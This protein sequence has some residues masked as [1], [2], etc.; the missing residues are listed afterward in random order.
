MFPCNECAKL[1]I[2]AGITEVVYHEVRGAAAGGRRAGA[3]APV[4]CHDR[5]WAPCT[6]RSVLGMLLRRQEPEEPSA[7][8]RCCWPLLQ[9]KAQEQVMPVRSICMSDDAPPLQHQHLHLHH[10]HQHHQHG[11]SG[12]S[13][14]AGAQEVCYLA[15]KRLLSLA[16]VRLRQHQLSHSV[17]LCG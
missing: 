4:S 2:Q 16:G 8:A 7:A 5:A 6:W 11:S 13:S 15:S 14:A 12:G 10:G 1:L 3:P 9:D 17:T